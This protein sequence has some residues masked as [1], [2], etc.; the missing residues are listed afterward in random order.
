MEL[1]VGEMQQRFAE[2]MEV[3]GRGEQVL[4][5]EDGRAIAELKPVAHGEPVVKKG[6]D[7][8]RARRIS[9]ELGLGRYSA[10]ELWPPEFD[11]P[12]Y[13]RKVLGLE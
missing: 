2:A 6:F 11:D 13:S 3:A 7:F 5:T 1:P 8:Q 10:E 4:V 12:A 9:E